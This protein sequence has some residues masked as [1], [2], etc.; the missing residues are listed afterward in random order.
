[1]PQLERAD[2]ELSLRGRPIDLAPIQVQLLPAPHPRRMRPAFSRRFALA[3]GRHRRAGSLCLFAGLAAGAGFTLL[4]NPVYTAIAV[5]QTPGPDAAGVR[6]LE[7]K[8]SATA[9][10]TAAQRAN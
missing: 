2:Q 3:V 6:S 9:P 8:E 10:R 1:M 4:E 7:F 5:I